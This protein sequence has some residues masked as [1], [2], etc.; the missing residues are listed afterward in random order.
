MQT[1]LQDYL[2]FHADR[3]P[4]TL[5]ASDSVQSLN[6]QQ[7]FARIERIAA[8]LQAQGLKKGDRIALIGKNSVDQVLVLIACACSGI[9]PVAMNYRLTAAEW[10]Y[11]IAD[12]GAGFLFIDAAFASDTDG[13]LKDIPAAILLGEDP[14]IPS[15]DAW[16]DAHPGDFNAPGISA[17]DTLFQIYTSGTTG[18]PKGV[19]LSHN[20]VT[21]NAQQTTMTNGKFPL[22][23]DRILVI[24]PLYHAG[25]LVGALVAL[26]FGASLTIHHDFNAREFI[27]TLAREKIRRTTAVPVMLQFAIS[28]VPNIRDY[29]F[30]N[31]DVIT[32][33]ASAISEDLLK[34][35][36]E[37]FGC[38]FGQGYG[39]TEATAGLTMLTSKDHRLALQGKPY[40]LRSC[41]RPLFGTEIRIVN[42]SGEEVAVGE[43]GEIIAR[44]PQV[45]Q[46]YWNRDE[47]NRETLRNGWLHT[48]DI[49]RI[50]DEGYIY[51]LDRKKDLIISG[52]ENI[53]PAEIEN[54]LMNHPYIDDVAVIGVADDKWGE[55]PFAVITIPADEHH[56]QLSLQELQQFCADKLA[57]YKIPKHLAYIESLPRN[58]SGKVLKTE[59]R[60][61]FAA[62]D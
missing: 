57:R 16:M 45:M 58:P 59:L 30:S 34:R 31:L 51:I 43:P 19:L 24:A 21:S 44:G 47:A 22:V 1:L 13:K 49:G 50:D 39:Q 18:S 14:Q 32:Y 56:P 23:G 17:D 10:E 25:G 41:G 46:G 15:L 6:K 26:S 48:G 38:D 60:K 7:A 61:R 52:A 54:I 9:V 36:M 3:H 4:E 53:Y 29:D 62:I 37:I 35:S 42:D 27:E 5:F 55:V 2:R 11:I 8:A 12:A 20:N 40:L 33:G 28:S